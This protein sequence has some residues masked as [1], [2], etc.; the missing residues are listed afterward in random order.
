MRAPRSEAS[1][2][3]RAA[4]V[5]DSSG[6]GGKRRFATRDFETGSWGVLVTVLPLGK[7]IARMPA[8][9]LHR[10]FLAPRGAGKKLHGG[11][12]KNEPALHERRS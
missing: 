9:D 5:I 8:F 2:T 4:S 3:A 7:I 6:V 10:P 12:A 1:R 11:S